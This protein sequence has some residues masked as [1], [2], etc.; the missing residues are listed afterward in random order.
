MV[1]QVL[2]AQSLKDIEKIVKKTK[3]PV[4]IFDLD[5]TLFYSSS[6]NLVIFQEFIKRKKIKKEFPYEV[7]QIKKIK[8]DQIEYR[9]DQTMNNLEISNVAFISQLKIFWRAR[10]FSNDYVKEDE[11]I[12]GSVAYVNKLYNL[13]AK[14][15]YLTGRNNDMRSGT[16]LSLKENKFP[17]SKNAILIT[18]KDKRMNDV[19]YKKSAFKD[20][21]L[22]G[23]VVGAFENEPKNLNAMLDYFPESTGFFL[24][25]A[26]KNKDDIPY[27]YVKWIK[28]YL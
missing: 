20:I 28:D 17:Y 23:T 13:G 10:F 5:D 6:R 22:L 16:I 7:K 18:K 19:I 3:N 26:R 21:E 12:G 4:I 1:T 2:F 27:S 9:F 11:V 25:I 8:R 15:V 24:D 14:I